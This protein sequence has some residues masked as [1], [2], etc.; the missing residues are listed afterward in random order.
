MGKNE[1][2]A[3]ERRWL[4]LTVLCFSLLVIVLDN[5]ILN[6]AIP[7]I[8]RE[9]ARHQQ[10]APVDRRLV[11]AG[12]RRACCS[13]PAP[14]V[15]ASVDAA[16]CRSASPS[17]AS[18]RSLSASADQREPADRHPGAHGHRRRVDHAG[19]PVD[20]HQRVPGRGA[21]AGHRRLGRCRRSRRGPR[22]AHRR[23]PRRAL[24]LGLGVPGEHPDRDRR[25]DRGR[26]AHPDVEGPVRAH[27]SIRSAPCCR[28]SVSRRCSTPSSR[29]RSEGWG[30][31]EHH[32]SASSPASCCSSRFV[33]W[34]RHTDHPMLDVHFFKNPRFTAASGSITLVF[35][36]MFGSIFLLTQYLQFVL[37]YSPLET[38]VRMLPFAGSDDGHGPDQRPH[39]RAHRH[40][41]HRDATGMVLVTLGLL[42][43]TTLAGRHRAT[44]RIGCA[45]CSWPSA[46]AWS[47]HRPPTRSWVRCRWPRPASARRSTTP[48]ARS[49]A[50]SAW[51]SS[52]AC[53]PRPTATR[54]ATSSPAQPRRPRPSPR[55]RARSAARSASP[56]S[57]P[58]QLSNTLISTANQAFVEAM[59]WGVVVAAIATA[60]G[61]FV[62]WFFLP[63][64][65][66]VTDVVEQD[67]RVRGRVGRRGRET[68]GDPVP[69]QHHA[70]GMAPGE[71]DS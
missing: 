44:G 11:H 70:T 67:S 43:M 41:G 26:R 18:A 58:Q 66:R 36:A 15:T 57:C 20:H 53:S 4:I 55:P 54:S 50:R 32:R 13:P 23:L 9:L 65:A 39:R 47:W 12:V 33:L 16:P 14:S 61:V 48:P 71:I 6:V 68:R 27:A 29:R 45:S 37:G 64:R 3:Y 38:G 69:V 63:A 40:Q 7:T 1:D 51:R 28:S 59:H 31:T 10:P 46:W 19:H 34:E 5:S 60:I 42:S 17:S 35:F 30:A 25:A 21:R 8:V 24:L 52:A 49:A 62:A 56:P 2:R 22:P